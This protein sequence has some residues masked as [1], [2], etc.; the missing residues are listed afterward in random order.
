MWFGKSKS[1]HSQ[2]D[3]QKISNLPSETKPGLVNKPVDIDPLGYFTRYGYPIP[4]HDL[5]SRQ[6][7]VSCYNRALRNPSWVIEHVTAQTRDLND[8]DRSKSH[9]KEDTGIPAPF[10]ARLADYF[11]SGYDKGHQ[12]P[13][14]D[15]RFSQSAM[16]ETFYLTN[17]SPQV[18]E[19]FNRDYWAHFERF[20]RNLTRSYDSIRI[21]TGPLYLPKKDPTS[22]KWVVSYE[23]IG[24]PPN[25]AVPTHFF[26]ILVGENPLKPSLPNKGVAVAAFVL[27]NAPIENSVP[28]KSYAVPVEA[29]ERAVGAEFLPKLPISERREL[30]KEVVC[31]VDIQE[32]NDTVQRLLPPP[33]KR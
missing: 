7:F 23:V 27:P 4:I 29:I 19:G 18:G 1:S 13:A 5:Q 26:K 20:A 10:R 14:A 30:C 2:A 21:V 6:E 12:A 3:E 15:A 32:F 8:G 24:N 17:M 22:G 33:S 16:D 25:I 28:L 11:R 9:F 31:D